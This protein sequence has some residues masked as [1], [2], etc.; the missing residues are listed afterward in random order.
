VGVRYSYWP[1]KE[2]IDELLKME[3]GEGEDQNGQRISRHVFHSQYM[4]SPKAVGGNIIHGKDFVRYT[5]VPKLRWRKVFADTAQKTKERHDYSVFEEWGFADGKIYLLALERGKWEAPELQKRAISFWAR[6]K[7]RDVADFGQCREMPIEDKVSGT[8]LIQ[9]LKLPPHNIPVKEVPRHTDKLTRVMDGLPYIEGGF[10]CV[11]ADAPFTT[12]LISECESFT[13]DDS[14]DYDDQIDPMMD[15]I[16]DMLANDKMK[17]WV[18]L[19][20]KENV[21]GK[22]AVRTTNAQLLQRFRTRR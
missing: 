5:V 1:Y 8:G 6:A 19:S 10:V 2:P 21:N 7:A 14:H 22:P 18:S 13:A 4:Q 17:T 20:K 16:S 12:D 15:A 11:P 3:R 9:A